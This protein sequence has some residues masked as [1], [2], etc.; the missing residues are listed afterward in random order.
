[1][2]ENCADHAANERT[3]RAWV[4]TTVAIVGFGIARARLGGA[5]PT[6]RA[7]AIVLAAGALVVALA[8][9]RMHL[10]RRRIDSNEQANDEAGRADMLLAP[11]V[12]A[13]FGLRG[14]FAL[15]LSV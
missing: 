4:R 11:M 8:Y 1:M 13:F 2:I 14:S 12:I 6:G 3:F 5:T 10:V 7:D 15:R 9:A